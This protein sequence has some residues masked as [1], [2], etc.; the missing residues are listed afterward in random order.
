MSKTKLM[1]ANPVAAVGGTL[2]VTKPAPGPRRH[3]LTTRGRRAMG[4]NTRRGAA[5]RQSS[6]APLTGLKHSS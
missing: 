1:R 4:R 3:P 2:H 6:S 5:P